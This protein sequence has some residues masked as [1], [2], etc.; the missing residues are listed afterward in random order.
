MNIGATQRRKKSRLIG[1]PQKLTR[2]EFDALERV[3]RIR[4]IK[5]LIPIGLMAV[6]RELE[7]EIESIL[8]RSGDPDGPFPGARRYGSNPGS[9]V[10][11]N[12]K[13]PVRVPRIR[14]DL[15]E[16]PLV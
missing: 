2:E 8:G 11:G 9:V 7:S 3:E 1:D 16:I 13:V 12:Q 15:G 6:G 14:S 4:L 10:L 5:R